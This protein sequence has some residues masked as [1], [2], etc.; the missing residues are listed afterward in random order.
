[1]TAAVGSDPFALLT[2]L[3]GVHDAVTAARS[4]VDALLRHRVM[5]RGSA[6]VT[7]EVSLRAARASAALEGHDVGLEALRAHLNRAL[8]AASGSASAEGSAAADDGNEATGGQPG[9]EPSRGMAGTTGTFDIDATLGAIRLY[10]ELGTLRGAWERA[11][12]QALARMHVLVARGLVADIDLGRPRGR[13]RPVSSADLSPAGASPT[14]VD[15]AGRPAA[16]GS[17]GQVISGGSP[18]AAPVVGTGVATAVDPADPLG[19]GPV[20]SPAETAARLGGLTELLL[21]RTSAPAIIVAA[22]V[23]GEL[24][25]IRPFGTFDG[26]IARAAGRLVLISRG[27][28]PKAVTATEVG[29]VESGRIITSATATSDVTT[30]D[31]TTSNMTSGNAPTGAYAEAARAYAGAGAEGVGQWI[32]YYARAL[33]LG[34]RE[35]LAICEAV[36]RAN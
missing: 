14:D 3:P 35:S 23:E 32:I 1:M 22:I 13:E 2:A 30:A 31:T 36:A 27:L 15:R 18:A 11:P 29:H 28:D 5:R 12:R 10:A 26:I 21:A 20:P 17:A 4:S 7:T 33:E 8:P 9:D 16:S 34:A 6:A 24:L 19:L 25:T